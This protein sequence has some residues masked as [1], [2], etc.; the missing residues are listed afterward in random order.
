VGRVGSSVGYSLTAVNLG[1]GVLNV[2][3]AESIEGEEVDNDS[4]KYEKEVESETV[5]NTRKNRVR[6]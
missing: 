5:M 4:D 3:Y 6:Y 2:I 1:P